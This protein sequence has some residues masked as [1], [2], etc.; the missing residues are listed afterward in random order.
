MEPLGDSS[1]TRS[2]FGLKITRK[3]DVVFGITTIVFESKPSMKEVA[4]GA[5]VFLQKFSDT[6]RRKEDC[7][8][9]KGL[10]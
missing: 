2:F 8:E 3:R 10:L 5:N 1:G 7:E 4:V 9:A 6:N